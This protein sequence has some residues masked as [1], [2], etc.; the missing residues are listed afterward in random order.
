MIKDPSLA[1]RLGLIFSSVA[2]DF[3]AL[4]RE[5]WD[6]KQRSR[7]LSEVDR[8]RLVRAVDFLESELADSGL[9]QDMTRQEY[10]TDSS[11]RRNIERW[12]E[13][14]VNASIDIA[15]IMLASR[16][17]QIPQTYRQVLQMLNTMPGMSPEI[18]DAL[19]GFSRLRNVLAHQY[20]DV[21]G[22]HIFRF[23][24]E[25]TG[26]YAQLSAA[27]RAVLKTP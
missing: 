2:E 5:F 27:A 8:D 4:T 6:I 21:R 12:V 25:A 11:R 26:A 23:L 20:I 3:R 9:F 13:N 18:A 16:Q 24:R 14:I 15:K 17:A 19:A 7:S 22:S 1:R 10:E